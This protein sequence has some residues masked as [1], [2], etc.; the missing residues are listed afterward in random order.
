MDAA[1]SSIERDGIG[2]TSRLE[3]TLFDDRLGLVGRHTPAAANEMVRHAVDHPCKDAA[4]AFSRNHAFRVSADTIREVVGLY[5]GSSSA[6]AKGKEAG[7]P[8][9]EGRLAKT[10]CVEPAC[11]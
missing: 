2:C 9:D 4:D 11:R 8:C 10:V 3:Q 7:E 1:A 5:R 6:F